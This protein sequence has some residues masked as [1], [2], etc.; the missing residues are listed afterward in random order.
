MGGIF[1]KDDD[2]GFVDGKAKEDEPD[3]GGAYPLLESTLFLELEAVCLSLPLPV[4]TARA[5]SSDD[6]AASREA[7]GVLDRPSVVE[8]TLV[9][10]DAPADDPSTCKE[11]LRFDFDSLASRLAAAFASFSDFLRRSSSSSIDSRMAS[12]TMSS[13]ML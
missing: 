1:K 6:L 8:E 13:S 4:K 11:D 9:D 10:V 5:L 3:A 7:R 2:V 12:M